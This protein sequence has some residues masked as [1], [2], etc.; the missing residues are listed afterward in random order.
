MPI[1]AAIR[2]PR[3]GVLWTSLPLSVARWSAGAEL[4]GEELEG[5]EVV[6]GEIATGHGEVMVTTAVADR[7]T[8]RYG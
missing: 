2:R 3:R 8:K 1:T 7:D 5:D 6:L 4:R